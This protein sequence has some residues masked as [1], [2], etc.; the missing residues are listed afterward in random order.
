M[1]FAESYVLDASVAVLALTGNSEPARE[2][3]ARLGRSQLHA[4]HLIDPEVGNVLRRK[5]LAGRVPEEM[6]AAALGVMPSLVDERYPHSGWLSQAAWELRDNVSFYDALY[7]ALAARLE[8]PLLTAD[9]RLTKAPDL[10]CAVEV[11]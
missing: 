3:L 4:P 6:A 10:P 2:M 5:V 9:V 11:V 8:L 7:V 1:R